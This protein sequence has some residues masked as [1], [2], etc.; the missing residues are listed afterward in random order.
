MATSRKIGTALVF[1]FVA[2][3]SLGEVASASKPRPPTEWQ[4]SLDAVV[5]TIEKVHPEP[6]KRISREKFAADARDL[7]AAMPR[8]SEAEAFVRLAEL[9][10]ELQDGHTTLTPDG[11]P[12]FSL[13]FPVRFYRFTDGVFVTA[14]GSTHAELA[15][16]K[17]LSIG[18]MPASE[19]ADRAANVFGA[20][21]EF[22]RMENIFALSNGRIMQGLGIIG[23]PKRLPLRLK[24]KDGREISIVLDAYDSKDSSFDW[25]FKSE[26]FGPRAYTPD[27]A[28]VDYVSAFDRPSQ[29]FRDHVRSDF[30][31]HLRQRSYYLAADVPEHDSYYVQIN[32][33]SDDPK[34]DFSTFTKRFM[35]QLDAHPRRNLIVDLRYNPGGD[36]SKA[37]KF[38]HEF[39]KREDNPPWK[40]LYVLTGRKSFSA[41]I[42]FLSAFLTHTDAVLIGEPAGAGLNHDGDAQ[43]FN[44]VG[45]ITLHC[46][47][48]RHELSRSDDKS[49]VIAVGIPAQFDSATYFSGGDPALNLIFSGEDMRSIDQIAAKDGP[50]A[51]R[52]IYLARK[53]RW[54]TISWW[55]AIREHELNDV[56]YDYLGS[57]HKDA[58]I[59]TFLLNAEAF[60]LDWNA[61]D[62]LGEA[63][64]ADGDI[65]A[66]EASYRKSLALNPGSESG[67]TAMKK[68]AAARAATPPH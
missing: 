65:D 25:R 23:D 5:A 44:L 38:I 56:G 54:G 20:N 16:A 49:D 60:P 3:V 19:A 12:A 30:P 39:I 2:I 43:D 57:G 28:N 26:V 41:T 9:V 50:A 66:A 15:G 37:V 11:R 67:Q 4:S 33:I 31:L 6:F 64:L 18:S 40:S 62:S 58:A 35:H 51:A 63:H 61:W 1:A 14:V 22:G 8:L 46:A 48:L 7:R 47:T 21:N 32:F 55:N 13:W 59:A 29:D 52:K 27:A 68:I 34:E 53:E 10:A 36:G 17:V 42:I 45:G 24:T